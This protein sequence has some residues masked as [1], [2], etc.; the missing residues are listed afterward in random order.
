MRHLYLIIA[1]LLLVAVTT[2]DDIS[3]INP[4]VSVCL[5]NSLGGDYWG[6]AG[7]SV[8]AYTAAG[9]LTWKGTADTGKEFQLRRRLGFDKVYFHEVTGDT[10]GLG[11][12]M[13][14]W[15]GYTHQWADTSQ[16]ICS[17][18]DTCDKAITVPAVTGNYQWFGRWPKA[19]KG[20]PV[21]TVAAGSVNGDTAKIRICYE[22]E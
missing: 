4:V 16:Y 1:G 14:I 5:K 2:A 9:A 7:D 15:N 20:R 8:Y 22:G 18:V 11:L 19:D 13:Q 12:R 6:I 10:V 17:T 21:I 3:G